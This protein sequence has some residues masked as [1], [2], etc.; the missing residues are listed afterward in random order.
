MEEISKQ[1]WRKYKTVAVGGHQTVGGILTLWSP[2]V[3]SLVAA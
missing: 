2:Q 3:L 1:H